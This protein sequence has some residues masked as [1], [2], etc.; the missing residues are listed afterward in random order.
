MSNILHV[1]LD[2]RSFL[3]VVGSSLA[4]A[5]GLGRIRLGSL[6]R[7]RGELAAYSGTRPWIGPDYWANSFQHWQLHDGW[8]E[9]LALSSPGG[10]TCNLLTQYL[11]AGQ[12]PA[13]LEV[14]TQ[15]LASGSGYSGFLVGG[16]GLALE[17]RAAAL[18][19]GAG[20]TNGGIFAVYTA[21]GGCAFYNHADESNQVNYPVLLNGQQ[22]GG[23]RSVGDLVHL[24][25]SISPVSGKG[26]SLK[27]SATDAK[28]KKLATATLTDVS[29][30][31]VK[32]G[33]GLVSGALS[34]SSARFAFQN[35]A[36][37]GRKVVTNKARAIGP[38]MATVFSLAQTGA[39]SWTLNMNVQCL[40][41]GAS[42][43]QALTL[44]YRPQGS[45]SAWTSTSA[46]VDTTGTTYQSFPS[47]TANFKLSDWNAS[48][49]WEYEV[50]WD[51][52]ADKYAGVVPQD[53]GVASADLAI[54]HITCTI[55]SFRPLDQ[56]SVAHSPITGN[57]LGLYT[58]DN[59]YFPYDYPTKPDV[60]GLL[61]QSNLDLLVALGDQY[62]ENCP[63]SPELDTAAKGLDLLYRWCVWL[64]A[65][66]GITANVPTI[67]LV[68][69]HDTLQ[70]N[71]WGHAGA[72][73]PGGPGDNGNY[74]EGGYRWSRDLINMMQR[75]QTGG[76][77]QPFQSTRALNEISVYYGSFVYGKTHFAV[78]EDRKF[79]DGDR[80]GELQGLPSDNSS[81]GLLGTAQDSFLT[82]WASFD[83]AWCPST[84]P[85]VAFSQTTWACCHTDGAGNLN[86]DYDTDGFPSTSPYSTS[87]RQSAIRELAAVPAVLISGD[88]HLAYVLRHGLSTFSDGIVQFTTPA[89]GSAFQRWFEGRPAGTEVTD[90]FGNMFTVLAV[91]NPVVSHAAYDAATGDKNVF[92][93]NLGDRGYASTTDQKVDGF[94]LLR[95]MFSTAGFS[96]ECWRHD[97]SE[98]YP[99]W[100]VAVA[101]ADM[102]L[103]D[104][105]PG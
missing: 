18:V 32:G 37:S 82:S 62:Y 15:M 95:V 39:A 17:P 50:L 103:S 14:D 96:F 24:T 55:H 75:C 19:Q 81:L 4:A 92:G 23:A 28:G 35:L 7:R 52:G 6:P 53:P 29:D 42:D 13:T 83:P 90:S 46:D 88:Q 26:L 77:P 97:G 74:N 41:I 94:G 78:L 1:E 59:I 11:K 63:H 66:R 57:L 70:G 49:A 31:S 72:Y 101:F 30:A 73:S 2:R 93:G 47:Y 45:A 21:E 89:A 40:P 64:W 48:R 10:S 54:G 38:I 34:G 105:V 56:P 33:I 86:T 60:A 8:I 102:H 27:L 12:L 76:N 98:Q 44:R 87:C 104:P 43:P 51:G 67:V 20:G 65:F 85:H 69:D 71:I 80:Y 3:K 84:H 68:D 9:C 36:A 5:W 25:L 61:E 79:K 58:H 100:P 99:G 91:A 22:S 16:G